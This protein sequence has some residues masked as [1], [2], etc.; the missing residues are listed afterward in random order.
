MNDATQVISYDS[1]LHLGVFVSS[2][3]PKSAPSM[4]QTCCWSEFTKVELENV[5]LPLRANPLIMVTLLELIEFA[6][7][8]HCFKEIKSYVLVA[9]IRQVAI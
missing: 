3:P 2:F 7:K 1:S 9:A 6:T 5:T 8:F 4:A